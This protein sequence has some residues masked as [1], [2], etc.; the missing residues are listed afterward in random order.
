MIADIMCEE[1]EEEEEEEEDLRFKSRKI[2][3]VSCSLG[4]ECTHVLY[5]SVLSRHFVRGKE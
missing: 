3:K 2:H 1:D 5:S 4:E